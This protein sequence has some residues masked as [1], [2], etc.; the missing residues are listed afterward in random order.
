MLISTDGRFTTL[1]S[2]NSDF[3]TA[4]NADAFPPKA[5]LTGPSLPRPPTRF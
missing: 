4:Y 2:R 1:R 5:A 3:E